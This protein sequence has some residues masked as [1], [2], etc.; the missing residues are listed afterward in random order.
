MRFAQ[1]QTHAEDPLHFRPNMSC[2]LLEL[3][4][5]LGVIEQKPSST[6][7]RRLEEQLQML[8]EASLP[9]DEACHVVGFWKAVAPEHERLS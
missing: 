4:T 8:L 5:P 3:L 7:L 9:I 1:S 2:T 6:E